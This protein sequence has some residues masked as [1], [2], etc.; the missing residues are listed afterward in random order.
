MD[1][2]AYK[3]KI[4]AACRQAVEASAMTT[5]QTMT[6]RVADATDSEETGYGDKYESKDEEMIDDSRRLEPHLDF[7]RREMVTLDGLNPETEHAE[8]DQGAV[9]ITDSLRFLVAVS[10]Q[11]EV[12]GEPFVGI[13][14]AAPIFQAMQ[15]KQAGDT[16][17]FNG[18]DFKEVF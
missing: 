4:I 1:K 14:I 17:G 12:N 5:H 8:I 18:N 10:A 6:Q 2:I 15:G 11:F 16:F 13:S 9:V 3:K 7:L